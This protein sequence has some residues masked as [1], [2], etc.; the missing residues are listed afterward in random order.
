MKNMKKRKRNVGNLLKQKKGQVT[1]FIIVAVVIVVLS[2]LIYMFYPKIKGNFSFYEKN[3]SAFIHDCLEKEIKD[4]AI[5]ISEQGGSIS[6]EHYFI[7]DDKRVE[8]LCYNEEYYLTCVVQQPML[9]NHI[10]SE[11]KENIK[12]KAKTCFEDLENTYKGKGYAVDLKQGE[13]NVELIPKK[14]AISF[15]S[16]L[17]LT[18]GKTETYK[19]FNIFVKNNLYELVSIANS[20]VEWET[21]YGDS[22]TTTYMNNYHDLKVEKKKHTDG[23]TIYILTD[24]NTG[25]KFQFASRSLAWPPGY[26]ASEVYVSQLT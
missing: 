11:I 22:E 1:I 6:P 7:Y 24:S 19:S 15:N 9:Y 26:G 2:V 23:T 4:S 16:T 10:E 21:T 17:T 18:K 8:Y 20:I 12:E 3:P 5:R 13:M 25:N 14:I